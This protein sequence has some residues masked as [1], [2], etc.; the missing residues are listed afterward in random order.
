MTHTTSEKREIIRIV[1]ESD[2]PI[3]TVLRQLQI[4]RSTFYAW[5]Q[6]YRTPDSQ[7]PQRQARKFWNRIPEETREHVVSIAL[8]KPEMTPRELSCH[9]TDNEG[10][11][12]SESS[13][14]RILKAR[15]LITSPHYILIS[16]SEKFKHLTQRINELWQTDFTYLHVVGWGWY[17]LSTVIDDYSR[18]IIAWKLCTSMTTVDVTATL[19]LARKRTGVERVR[20][21]QRT[22]LLSD[23][24]SCYKS[25]DLAE[26]LKSHDMDQTHGRPYHP[27]TQGKIERYHRTMKNIIKLNK[28]YFP[29]ELEKAIADFVQWYNNE[30]YHESID[31]LRPIDMYNGKREEILAKR[32]QIKR[33]TLKDRRKL[34]LDNRKTNTSER[35]VSSRTKT[36]LRFQPNMSKKL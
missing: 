34:N 17:Y 2:A 29:W 4:P 23:N 21:C 10:Y 15:D 7:Q 27:Q 24:G 11:F 5:Y 16:A 3:S 9:I 32:E 33:R 19:D 31:N 26:Y 22:R 18:C 36:S 35:N 28:Y 30:R 25:D 20:V 6:R 12:I 14:Y 1:E 13:V 8:D